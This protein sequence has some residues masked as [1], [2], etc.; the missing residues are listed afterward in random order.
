MNL[1]TN[2]DRESLR[3]A[4]LQRWME[5]REG[6]GG[7]EGGGG[8][9][10]GSLNKQQLKIQQQSNIQYLRVG[11]KGGGGAEDKTKLENLKDRRVQ[12]KRCG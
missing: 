3:E 1:L 10:R 2:D 4:S 11:G 9:G 5:E 12:K 7:V 6:G 8:G